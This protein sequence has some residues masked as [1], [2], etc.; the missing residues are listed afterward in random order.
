MYGDRSGCRVRR[1]RCVVGVVVVVIVIVMAVDVMMHHMVMV[2]V[3]CVVA[4]TRGITSSLV[5]W[6]VWQS[7]SQF[8]PEQFVSPLEVR[9]CLQVQPDIGIQV[10]LRHFPEE[11]EDKPPPSVA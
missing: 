4:I 2:A 1:A 9:V 6:N 11:D 3:V 5:V 8:L 7:E 10:F